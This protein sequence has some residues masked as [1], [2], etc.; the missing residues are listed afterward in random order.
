MGKDEL[1]DLVDGHDRRVGEATI[2]RCLDEGLRHRAVAVLVVRGDGRVIIQVRSKKDHWQPG[3]WTLS[4][5]GHV[6]AGEAYEHAARRELA[7]ELG[8]SS[9]VTFLRKLF[10][11]KVKSR[12]SIEWEVVSLYIAMTDAKPSID[13]V[14]LAGVHLVDSSGLDRLMRGRRLTP[15][16]KILLNECR[17]ST[18]EPLWC[19]RI[20]PEPRPPGRV[21]R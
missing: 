13:P 17:R 21:K 18:L 7:E 4:C 5:T 9:P 3:R 6:Q 12:G 8:L 15:D 10:L 11:P 20:R 16:A 1:V 19:Q 2:E 14:E